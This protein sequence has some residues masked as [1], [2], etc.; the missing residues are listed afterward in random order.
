MMVQLIHSG[1]DHEM[2]EGTDEMRGENYEMNEWNAWNEW[3]EWNEDML[4]GTSCQ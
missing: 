1:D 4:I 3:N 2:R